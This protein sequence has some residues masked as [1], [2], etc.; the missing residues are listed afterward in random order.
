MLAGDAGADVCPVVEASER[1]QVMNLDPANTFWRFAG[2]GLQL[3]VE[4]QRLI[5]LV[6]FRRN[7]SL[8]SPILFLGLGFFSARDRQ[9][10]ADEF[11]AIHAQGTGGDAGMLACLCAVVAVHAGYL[12]LAG[13]KAMRE[14]NGLHWFISLLVARQALAL[15]A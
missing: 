11:V 5:E 13:M 4:C 3:V 9:R 6:K 12:K 1:W 10:R 2:H 7:C 15:Q 8:G 14:E